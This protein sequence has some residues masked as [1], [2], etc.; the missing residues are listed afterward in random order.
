MPRTVQDDYYVLMWNFFEPLYSSGPERAAQAIVRYR[1]LACNGGTCTATFVNREGYKASLERFG[2]PPA[3]FDLLD[4]NTSPFLEN[5]FPFYV[6]NL[7][8]PL[9]WDWSSAKPVLR[10][11]YETFARERDRRVFVHTPCVNNPEVAEEM[12]RRTAEILEGLRPARHLSLLYDLRDEPSIT[13]FLLAG[14]SC[15][16]EHC[17]ARMREWLKES[18][19][20]LAALNGEWE[21]EFASW[22]E[23]EPITTQE[24]LA[25]REQGRWNFAPWHDHRAFMNE[26]FARVCQEQA[27]VIRKHDSEAVVGLGGTQCPWTFGGY[28]FSKLVPVLDWVEAYDFGGSVSCCRSFKAR[29]DFRN[30]KTDF[31]TGGLP[32]EAVRAMLWSYVFQAGGHSGTIVWQSNVM[33]DVESEGLEPT[34]PGRDHAG[35]Y[36]ELR[37]GL[38]KLLQIC[39]ERSSPVAVHYSQAS[40]NADFITAVPERWRS[41]AASEAERFPAYKCREA[42]WKL[43]EDRGLR[44]VF[45]SDQQVAAGE[46]LKRGVKLLVL[47][48]SIAVSDAEAAAMKEFVEAGGVFLADSFAGRMDEHCREREAGVLDG[49]LGVERLEVD[50]Y[51]SSSQRASIDYD[52]K[53]GERP[54]WGGGALRAECALVEER[55]EPL[56]GTR[57]LGCTEYTDTPL[58]IVTEHGKGKAILLNCAPLTYLQARRTAAGGESFQKFFGGALDWAGV[59]PEVEVC[60]TNGARLSGWQVFGFGHGKARYFGV[61]PDLGVSQDVLGG[62]EVDGGTGAERQVE[63]KLAISGHVYEARV[64]AYLGEGRAVRDTLG[65]TS[66]KVYAVMPYKVEGVELNFEGGAARASL[67]TSKPAGEHVLRFD[68]FDAEDSRLLDSGANVVASGGTAEWKPEGELPAGGKMVCRDVATGVSAEVGL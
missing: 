55:I 21:T 4:A 18:Y 9:Y 44:P 16:C 31:V 42:W 14:D 58:G 61:G 56:D 45:V 22:D 17:L 62:M 23:V 38:P 63:V 48:R 19:G 47:P 64:G 30:L 26:T 65:P 67:K 5:D 25:R 57:I 68:L 37:S 50:N 29:R 20:S 2:L 52:A 54:V 7:C 34:G 28:D 40:I 13:S 43:L 49:L 1:E 6:M 15:F 66:V 11:Q 33:V 59:E 39:E 27:G 51:H 24:A 60:S 12:S 32:A 35:V 53:A 3:K 36:A 41:V 10:K 8:R 46:L